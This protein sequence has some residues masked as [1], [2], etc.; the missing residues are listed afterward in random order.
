MSINTSIEID[1]PPSVVRKTF[2]DFQSYPT[3]NP[4]I[5]SISSS[6]PSAPKGS[7]IKFTASGTPLE[8]IVQEN[9]SERFSWLGKLIAESIFKGHHIFEFE[10]LGEIGENGETVNCKFIQRE[11]FGGILSVVLFLIR[12]KTEK[13]FNDMN[14]ALKAR[15]EAAAKA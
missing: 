12:E 3:W 14:M 10:S 11:N 1:A 8:S 4:F 6:E 5:T 13:G 2:F 15:A 7:H 9:T